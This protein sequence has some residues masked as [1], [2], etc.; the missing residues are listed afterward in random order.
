MPAYKICWMLNEPLANAGHSV[1]FFNCDVAP[2]YVEIRKIEPFHSVN[3]DLMLV[4][5]IVN[6]SQ[7][8][9]YLLV[10]DVGAENA[11]SAQRRGHD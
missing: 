11:V 4:Q 10:M 3:A 6:Y 1:S 8:C 9:T 7:T 5:M 2:A